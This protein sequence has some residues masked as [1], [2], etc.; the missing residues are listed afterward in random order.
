MKLRLKNIIVGSAMGLLIAI[1]AIA[2][3]SEMTQAADSTPLTVAGGRVQ[4][5]QILSPSTP[6]F[7]SQ[8]NDNSVTVLGLTT[9]NSPTVFKLAGLPI[10]NGLTAYGNSYF[11]RMYTGYSSVPTSGGIGFEAFESGEPVT[12]SSSGGIRI[13][14]L[15]TS[16]GG[17]AGFE[18]SISGNIYTCVNDFGVL[19]KCGALPESASCGPAHEG[20][21]SSAPSSGLCS[22]GTASSVSPGGA[23]GGYDYTWTCTDGAASASCGSYQSSALINGQC[24]S[25]DGGTYSSPP[26]SN[27]CSAGSAS[28]VNDSGGFTEPQY[29]WTCSGS[30]GGS[31]D[32]C[33]ANYSSGGGGSLPINGQCGSADGGTYSSPPSSNLCSAGNATSVQTNPGDKENPGTYTWDCNGTDGGSDDS[34]SATEG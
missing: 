10:L 5:L 34:C 7:Y 27:L 12:L 3:R 4:D 2:V 22:S 17:E 6:G 20:S 23:R 33:S 1:G 14:S 13:Q 30:G 32:S 11:G 31:D 18:Q 29:T 26:S 19:Q 25:A 15:A 8:S 21:T 16:G 24:G 28:S 9:S